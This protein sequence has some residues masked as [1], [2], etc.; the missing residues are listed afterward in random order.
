MTLISAPA[1]VLNVERGIPAQVLAGLP[2]RVYIHEISHADIKL[3]VL[4]HSHSTI[5]DNVKGM[6]DSQT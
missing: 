2:V 4:Y 3:A 1:C 6:R 5:E